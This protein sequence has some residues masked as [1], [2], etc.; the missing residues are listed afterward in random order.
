[1][2]QCDG[3]PGDIVTNPHPLPGREIIPRE[4]NMAKA[5]GA[6]IRHGGKVG[7]WR[8]LQENYTYKG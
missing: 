8:M 2:D 5:S 4:E 6:D 7:K 1:M 3:L